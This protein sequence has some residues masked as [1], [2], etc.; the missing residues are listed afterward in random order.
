LVPPQA[1]TA[2][3]LGPGWDWGETRR[4]DR[5]EEVFIAAPSPRTPQHD[6]QMAAVHNESN[7]M[8]AVAAHDENA[9]QKHL[10]NVNDTVEDVALVY[11]AKMASDAEHA[12]SLM[13]GFRLY[14][15]A[16]G[17]SI[18][19]STSL[20]MEGY[21][22]LLINSL[23]AQPTFARKY[24]S[25]AGNGTYQLT[26]AWQSGLSNGINAGEILG[27]F[28]S[29]WFADRY[30][31]RKVIGT[32]LVAIICFLFITFFSP[33]IVVLLVGEILCGLS[34]GVFQTIT[35]T[36]AAEVCPVVLRCYLTT[37]VN[38][39]W[40][41][42]QLI[43]SGVLRGVSGITDQWGYRIPF[44]VQ[45]IWPVPILIAVIL[46]PESPWWLVRKGRLAE[47]EKV[48]QRLA[49]KSETVHP[50]KTVAMMVHTNEIEK[51][52]DEGF[53]YWDCFKG[54]NLRRT[55]IACMVWM[56]Q[57]ICG[58]SLMGNSSYFYEQAGLPVSKSFDL[59][60]GQYALGAVGTLLS[61]FL[62]AR[63]G[64]RT[65][66]VYGLVSLTVIL[67]IIGFMGIPAQ[68]AGLSWGTGSLMLIYVF[69]YDLTVGPVCYSLVS[70]IPSSRM[71][72]KTVVMARN[73]YNVVGFFSNTITPYMLNP[74][75]WGW[76]GKAGFFWG[77]SCLLSTIYC[78]FRLPEPSGRSFAELDL[79]FDNRISARKFS[80]TA[81]DPYAMHNTNTGHE[82]AQEKRFGTSTV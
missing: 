38:L 37:Y 8:H 9:A 22:T 40:V 31:Y 81:V 71:R 61:W 26:A 69:L 45:W 12:M 82:D 48:V 76:A 65:I 70:E 59:S 49:S 29:G 63:V 34:W 39:C 53:T 51:Q 74:T 50:G 28:A 19:L 47:A 4:K 24:G 56:I 30:G 55:E 52:M 18:A 60:I 73:T 27:L 58:N 75:A 62:M 25:P 15:K 10:H 7:T 2:L 35:V 57:N 6:H 36:Y 1:P 68:N 3:Y 44:A 20:I 64:R 79:L 77:A 66:Y 17:W 33:T 67:F 14:P 78:Y 11:N 21:D 32:A 80:K 13:Q 23:F 16:M 5:A 43:G 46:A 72:Q 42:G 41:F 54:V